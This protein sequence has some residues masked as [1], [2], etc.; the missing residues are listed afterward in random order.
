MSHL[1]R[2]STSM[3][4][5]PLLIALQCWMFSPKR[6]RPNFLRAG[7]LLSET[8]AQPDKERICRLIC[9]AC[10]RA[11]IPA[12]VI[13]HLETSR[14]HSNA[15]FSAIAIKLASL[16]FLQPSRFRFSRVQP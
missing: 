12:S 1:Q 9:W 13:E 2:S 16:I 7:K 5:V 15:Q 10:A 11:A 3:S 6:V 14:S 4:T 8:K